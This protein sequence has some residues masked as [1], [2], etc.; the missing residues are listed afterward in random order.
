MPRPPRKFND[1]PF[2]Y[3]QEIELRVDTLT[4]LGAGLG[5]IDGWVVMVPFSLP[6]ERIRARVF[7]NQKG[8]SE[9]DLME[10]LDPSPHRI[11]ATCDLFGTCGGCQYQTFTYEEQLRWKQRQV[12][13]LLE[14]MARIPDADV[15]PVIPSPRTYGYR[16]KITP[17]F[18]KPKKPDQDLGPIGFLRAGQRFNLVDVPHCPIASDR[19]NEALPKVREETHAKAASFKKGATLLLRDSASREVLTDSHSICEEHV[20]DITFHTQDCQRY[21]LHSGLQED[22][23]RLVSSMVWP[24]FPQYESLRLAGMALTEEDWQRPAFRISEADMEIDEDAP[25]YPPVFDEDDNM[26]I[27]EGLAP[28]PFLGPSEEQM[29]RAL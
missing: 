23:G 11:P 20:G 4:N 9:A 25:P 16:S 8:H 26:V 29:L 28:D 15:Q 6:G 17:H 7:R 18:Q 22:D 1:H 14:K 5:R 27:L 19:I 13:E 10:V 12:R 3:H 24:K 2:A 21:L